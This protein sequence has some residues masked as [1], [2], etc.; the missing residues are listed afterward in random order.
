MKT[1]F[2]TSLSMGT[3]FLKERMP[4]GPTSNVADSFEPFTH[5]PCRVIERPVVVAWMN[6]Y[7]NEPCFSVLLATT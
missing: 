1:R 5:E 3:K 4:N 6:R 2:S 7:R